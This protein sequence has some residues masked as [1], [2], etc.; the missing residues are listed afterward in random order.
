MDEKTLLY[1][2]VTLAAFLIGLSKGGFGGTMGVLI[3]PMVALVLPLDKAAGLMLPILMLGDVFALTA[4]WKR[5]DGRFLRLLLPAAVIGITIGTLVLAS[6]P[7]ILLKRLLGVIVI[8]FVLYRLLE[9]KVTARLRYQPRPWHGWLAGSVA[10]FTSTLAHSGGPPITIYLLLQQAPPRAFVATAALFL[11]VVNLIK[12]PYYL[13]ASLV[14]FELLRSVVWAILLVPLGA[15]VG[16]RWVSRVD[17][18]LFDRIILFF[19]T[20]TAALL[21]LR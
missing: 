15:W 5:W 16:R 18:V 2:V 1:L 8:I 9:K 10:G 14:D 13:S 7:P 6:F 21:L 3:T 17:K 20:I 12:L 4:H 19:L 11:A